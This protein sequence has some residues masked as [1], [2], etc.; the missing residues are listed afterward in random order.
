MT[1]AKSD[2]SINIQGRPPKTQFDDDI[3]QPKK[4]TYND[5]KKS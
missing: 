1:I 5:G 2:N 3:I 4:T